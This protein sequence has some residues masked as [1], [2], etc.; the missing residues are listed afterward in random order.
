MSRLRALPVLNLLACE[1]VKYGSKYMIYIIAFN[2]PMLL[3][4]VH[5]HTYKALCNVI[6]LFIPSWH[7]TGWSGRNPNLKSCGN[8]FQFCLCLSVSGCLA[9]FK[10]KV[11]SL[12]LRFGLMVFPSLSC[13]KPQMSEKSELHRHHSVCFHW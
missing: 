3:T 9:L 5:I 13:E 12:N 11:K 2:T 8:I 4:H 6:V 1:E 7:P 10:S